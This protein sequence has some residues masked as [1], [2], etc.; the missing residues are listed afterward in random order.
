MDKDPYR[1]ADRQTRC[2]ECGE[3]L[4]WNREDGLAGQTC[5]CGHEFTGHERPS[6]A[7]P[8]EVRE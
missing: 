1:P 2:P 3:W 4:L 8:G 7:G 5:Q 6:Q